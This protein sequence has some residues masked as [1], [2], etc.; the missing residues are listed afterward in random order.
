MTLQHQLRCRKLAVPAILFAWLLGA[1]AVAED[2]GCA[3]GAEAL[4]D[5]YVRTNPVY[6]YYLGDLEL[7]VA[8]NPQHFVPGGDAVRCA[9]AL[10]QA[11]VKGEIQGHA[12]PDALRRRQKLDSQLDTMGIAPAPSE[13]ATDALQFAALSLQIEHLARV[14]PRV[15]R[16][17]YEALLTASNQIE[18]Q[19]MAVARNLDKLYHDRSA[20]GAFSQLEKPIREVADA[21]HQLLVFMAK[22]LIARQAR[23]IASPNP[24]NQ[25]DLA[26]DAE[27]PV[28][29][30]VPAPSEDAV[31]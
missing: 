4:A 3:T 12:A 23:E 16:G 22:M 31:Q 24:A 28:L 20:A 13:G 8:L 1:P 21:E 5:A 25:G 14:L 9:H 30:E 7:Y 15:A 19:R 26:G 10:A 11:L 29:A 2:S 27:V 17:D 18:E 6:A